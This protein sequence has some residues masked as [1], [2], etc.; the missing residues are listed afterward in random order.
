MDKPYNLLP[1]LHIAFRTILAQ[2][3]SRH[4]RGFWRSASNVW[5]V[6]VGLST[7]LTYQHHFMDVAAGFA[8]GVCCIYFV[9]ESALKHPVIENRRIGLYYAA[10][11]LVLAC[12][13]VW[14]WPWG[15]L[16]LW[17]MIALV[18]VASAYFG[19]GP[20]VFHKSDGRLHWSAQLVLAPCLLGQWLS[21]LYYRR[22]CRPWDQVTPQIWIG[23][24]LSHAEAA[25]A[26]RL[27]VTAVLDLTAEFSEPKP[28][29]ALIYRNIPIL[30]LTA[31]SVAQLHEMAAFIDDESR[32]GVVYIHCKIG[33]SRTAA[34]AAAYLLSTG[35]ADGVAE[36]IA[37]LREVR[38]SIVVRPEVVSA[39]AE[40][41][42]DLRLIEESSGPLFSSPP[43]VSP[44]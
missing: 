38:P 5:F 23:R 17:P 10:A 18:I 11:A 41:V 21:L 35:K 13:V 37:L 19:L 25:A 20:V 7:L 6:L 2:H 29:R 30:D 44:P 26:T 27:G 32:K 24:T 12:P 22:Q 1:S 3:Y 15:A 34:A 42:R 31:P 28:F 40:F 43:G 16:F 9:R 33:Y 14:F 36:A 4:T 8:L 39:L